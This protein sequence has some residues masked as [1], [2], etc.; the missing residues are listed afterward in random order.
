MSTNGSFRYQPSSRLLDAFLHAG[1]GNLATMSCT[2][3]PSF[4]L[5]MSIILPAMSV[6]K[7]SRSRG[8]WC[9]K[10]KSTVWVA[11]CW[12]HLSHHPIFSHKPYTPFEYTHLRG[13]KYAGRSQNPLNVRI[14][15]FSSWEMVLSRSYSP[16]R[17]R[18]SSRFSTI[19]ANVRSGMVYPVFV[20]IILPLTIFIIITFLFNC[21]FYFLLKHFVRRRHDLWRHVINAFTYNHTHVPRRV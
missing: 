18:C 11:N 8:S 6:P 9:E 20:V 16:N 7:E 1:A 2:T 10:S 21:P 19:R 15:S 13:E 3:S 12:T 14:P 17:L 5:A 4:S